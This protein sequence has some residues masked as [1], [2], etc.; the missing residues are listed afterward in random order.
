LNREVQLLQL[1]LAVL[2]VVYQL[3]VVNRW[4]NHQLTIT[5]IRDDYFRLWNDNLELSFLLS[6]SP[7]THLR[8]K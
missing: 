3:Q 6:K 1:V 8:V 5:Y 4:Y 2:M 7:S